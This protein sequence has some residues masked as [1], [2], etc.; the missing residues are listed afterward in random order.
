MGG[1]AEARSFIVALGPKG[2][3]APPQ[4]L[5]YLASVVV[6]AAVIGCGAPAQTPAGPGEQ[7]APP[8]ARERA[9]Q[10]ALTIAFSR[11]PESLEISRQ[12]QN[13]EWGALAS[14]FLAS[15]SPETQAAVP[16][17]AE[18]LPSV[19]KG[20]WKILPD[21][22]METTY[23][24]RK[25]ATWHDGQPV[26]AHDWAFAYRVRLD[27]EFLG[28][29]IDVER[30]LG[31]AVALDDHTLFLEWREPFLWAGM[32]HLPE[33]P[34]MPRHK[35]ES[36]Y[37]Q[38]RA[39]F[40]DGPHWREQ[41]LGSGP[42]RVVSWEPGVDMIFRAHEGFVFGK[43]NIDEVRVRFIGDA[44]TIVANLLSGDLDFSMSP[45]IGFAQGQALEQAGFSGK[46][47]YW[48]GLPRFLEY[49][50]RD[51]GNTQR[52]VFDRRVRQASHYAIDRQAIADTI[53]AGR[54]IVAY[55]W[56]PP[57]DPTHA[58]VTRAAPKYEYD[59]SR[60]EA[61]LR[62]AGWVKG[63]DGRARNAAG[64]FLNITIQTLPPEDH[65]LDA[66]VVA[67]N[68]K[69]VGITSEVRRLSPA[70]WR[71]NELRSKFP[72]VAYNTRG[73]ALAD[74]VWLGRN[75]STPE[76]RWGGQNRSGYVNPRLDE[77]WARALGS[78]D[79]KE[80]E[81]HLIE[82]T[83]VMVEDAMVVLTHWTPDVVA[84]NADIIGPRENAVTYTSRIW[85]IW[86]WRWR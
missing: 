57:I 84:Y 42:Y 4:R 66:A 75:L 38:D 78:I 32:V 2:G 26:T 56:V 67:N 21:G 30:R 6:L 80:R 11:E 59:P 45:F 51:W 65:Q 31:Q 41:Y 3:W 52:A 40:M 27:P 49:Q 82:A 24:I 72:G 17:L 50:G 35:L 23:K 68:W 76:N 5:R 63:A 8:S 81:G 60:A 74:M 9:P 33:F 58:A 79:Q 54:A 14:G 12:P 47:E 71:D 34:P 1:A 86:E 16:Y 7:A 64:D 77:L 43:P 22:R 73:A 61:L 28:H 85:N 36:L 83:T 19:E 69:A 13:R 62:E 10:R 55:H 15:F 37:L 18:E 29:S 48:P 44:N 46:T 53:F 70:E 25:N 20:T 39:A